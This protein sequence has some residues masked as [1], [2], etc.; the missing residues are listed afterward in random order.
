MSSPDYMANIRKKA[1]VPSF[2]DEDFEFKM[3]H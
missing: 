1:I 2:D 3:I